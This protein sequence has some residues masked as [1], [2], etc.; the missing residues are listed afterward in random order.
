MLIWKEF[1]VYNEN[2]LTLYKKFIPF[3]ENE[4][5]A[6]FDET[7]IIEKNNNVIL[8]GPYFYKKYLFFW[9]FINGCMISKMKLDSG[10]SDICLW[11][12]NYIF[13]SYNGFSSPKFILINTKYNKIEK[14]Y[15]EKVNIYNR[16]CGIKTIR[17][18]T[19]GNYIIT[20]TM[21]GKLNLY[22]ICKQK[23]LFI[24]PIFMSSIFFLIL[25]IIYILFYKK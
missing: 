12:N 17:H 25:S 9:D 22:K 15:K 23:K 8:I 6:G 5:I 11:D 3:F 13:A 7:I 4:K 2:D 24:N 21:N 14:I 20:C 16:I 10:I 1:F 18:E 19:K